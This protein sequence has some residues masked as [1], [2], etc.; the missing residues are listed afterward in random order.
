MQRRCEPG[1]FVDGIHVV[2]GDRLARGDDGVDRGAH[3][4]DTGC[5]LYYFCRD[6]TAHISLEN[7][8]QGAEPGAGELPGGR[9]AIR[10]GGCRA[11]DVSEGPGPDEQRAALRGGECGAGGFE[12]C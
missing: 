11:G 3:V 1:G 12:Q 9:P 2:L 4:G 7:T 10:I 8:A 5:G 6:G